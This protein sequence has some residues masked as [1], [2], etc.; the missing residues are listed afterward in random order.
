MQAGQVGEDGRL[1]QGKGNIETQAHVAESL[2]LL[3]EAL[4]A[5]LSKS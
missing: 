1:A 5:G 3:Q 2:A 4:K